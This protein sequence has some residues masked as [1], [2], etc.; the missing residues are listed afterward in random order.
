MFQRLHQNY[1]GLST[2]LWPWPPCAAVAQTAIDLTA[3]L[4]FCLPRQ[5]TARRGSACTFQVAVLAEVSRRYLRQHDVLSSPAQ[6]DT[7][8]VVDCRGIPEA[9]SSVILL[10]WGS[11]DHRIPV[12]LGTDTNEASEP[13]KRKR[14]DCSIGI[15]AR[16]LQRSL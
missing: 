3:A 4:Q 6:R 9:D 15:S 12:C 5:V 13:K 7:E 16:H 8:E 11:A 10:V 14:T 2:L 1:S